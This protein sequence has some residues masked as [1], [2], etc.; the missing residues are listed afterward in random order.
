MFDHLNIIFD[1]FNIN[2]FGYFNFI[3]SSSKITATGS[4]LYSTS[5]FSEA[6]DSQYVKFV[7]NSIQSSE[8]PTVDKFVIFENASKAE[9]I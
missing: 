4:S 8:A 3:S 9:I 7:S 1:Q 5:L 2:I 6:A